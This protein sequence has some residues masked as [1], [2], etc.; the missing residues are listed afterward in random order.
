MR[1]TVEFRGRAAKAGG[2]R[3]TADPGYF[4]S[5]FT[6]TLK[7]GA[8]SKVSYFSAKFLI[9]L[10]AKSCVRRKILWKQSWLLL[11]KTMVTHYLSTPPSLQNSANQKIAKEI[12]DEISTTLPNIRA[13][14]K[15]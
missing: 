12:F 6:S 14:P 10:D 3:V 11:W 4:L 8:E 2:A 15:R 1:R 9:L 5:T 7:A 13:T